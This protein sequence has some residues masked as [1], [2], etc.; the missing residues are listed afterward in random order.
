MMLAYQ[1]IVFVHLIWLLSCPAAANRF[2]VID[3]PIKIK[4]IEKFPNLVTI[5]DR[6]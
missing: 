2:C 6:I 3:K 4:N 5:S 1:P